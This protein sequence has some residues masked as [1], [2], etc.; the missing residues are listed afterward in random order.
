MQTR[1]VDGVDRRVCTF[2]SCGFVHWDNPV[3]VVAAL[4]EYHDKIILARNA[5]WP[6]GTFSFVAGY[7]EKNE[8]PE[9]AVVR[10]VREELNLTGEVSEFVGCFPFFEKN[11]ILLVYVVSATGEIMTGDE[12]A[13]IRLL[14]REELA[15]WDFGKFLLTANVVKHWLETPFVRHKSIN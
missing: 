10:E 6:E 14:S 8:S 13:E 12:I 15:A 11:Q 3:P 2:S 4:I 9:A 5:Q 1:R 7:L